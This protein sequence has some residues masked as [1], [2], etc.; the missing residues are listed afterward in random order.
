MKFVALTMEETEVPGSGI[1]PGTTTPDHQGPNLPGYFPYLSLVFKWIT[2]LI[3]LMMAGWVVF[4]IQTTRKLHKPHNIFVAHLMVTDIII[5]VFNT[6]AASIMMIGY[7]TGLGDFINCRVFM[8]S[9]LTLPV[10]VYITYLMIS[11]NQLIAIAFP[12]EYRKIMNHRVIIGSLTVAWLVA[13]LLQVHVFFHSGYIKIAQYGRCNEQED[14]SVILSALTTAV[15]IFAISFV[16]L[17]LNAYLTYKA[18]EIQRQIQKESK[19]S[20]ATSNEVNN[21]KKKQAIIK[22]HLKP[23]ITLLVVVL[24]SSAI[25]LIV[26]LIYFPAIALGSPAVYENF[27]RYGVTP[28][29]SY[30]TILL[31]PFVY[32][33]YYKQVREPMMKVLKRVTCRKKFNSVAPQPRRTAW[34]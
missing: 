1:T 6:V 9:F 10:V 23:M 26:P 34:M 16:V 7:A 17:I 4:T 20:G 2:T 30:L 32:G 8:F 12:Y 15:P 31:H 19:L 24:G 33:L 22:T 28:N 25:G 27:L 11:V 3:I 29:I 21:L 18:Y 13:I 5:A 14:D